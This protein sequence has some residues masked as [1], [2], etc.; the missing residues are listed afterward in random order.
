MCASVFFCVAHVLFFTENPT[1]IKQIKQYILTKLLQI[2]LPFV[3][4]NVLIVLMVIGN[5]NV[6][7]V[8][9]VVYKWYAL[10][11]RTFFARV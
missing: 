1:K 7:V 4:S 11:T 2:K 9:I 8:L 6:M 10:A 5:D 3:S